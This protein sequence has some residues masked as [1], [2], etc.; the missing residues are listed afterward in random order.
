MTDITREE[1]H[2]MAWEIKREIPVS[3]I[4]E[5][6]ESQKNTPWGSKEAL[7]QLIMDYEKNPKIYE[8]YIMEKS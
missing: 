5:F 7:N 4:K 1:K 3:L 6:I 8:K 2:K